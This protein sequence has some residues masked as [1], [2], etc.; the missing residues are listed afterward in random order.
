MWNFGVFLFWFLKDNKY[1]VG[2]W[3][4]KVF[5]GC[6]LDYYCDLFYSVYDCGIMGEFNII[7]SLLKVIGCKFR[8]GCL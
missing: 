6:W 3:R 4:L 1:D 8:W 2:C 5:E 7:C